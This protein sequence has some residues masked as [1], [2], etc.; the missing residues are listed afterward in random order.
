MTPERWR[1]IERLYH[2]ALERS[3][4]ERVG[5]LREA[6]GDD[7]ALR[8]E[9]ESLFDSAS[10]AKD[11]MERPA[12]PERLAS[13]M[14]RLEQSSVPGRFVGR[15]FGAYE[16]Q[17]LIAAGGMGEVYRAVDTRLNRTVAI[18]TLP[19]HLSN[20]PERRERFM[21]E[22]RIVSSLNHPHICTLHDVGSQDDID[23]LVM[24]HIDG[25]TLQ[26]RLESGR[27]PLARALEYAIQIVD[28]L[29]KAHRRGVIHRDLKPGNVMVTKSGVKLLDFGLA[30]RYTPAAVAFD[31]IAH[32]G[33]KGLTAKG[34]IVGTLQYIA[35]E[36]LE[37]R[38]VDTRTDIFAFG[39]LAYEMITGT[40]AF[41]AS[42]QAQL[43][44]AILK[45]NPQPI[46]DSVPD[47]P[48]RLAQ[49]IARCLAKDPD[50]RW[51]SANDLLFELRSIVYPPAAVGAGQSRRRGLPG[52]VER[53][54]WAAAIVA[55]VA[56]T[57][58]LARRR[59]VRPGDAATGPPIRYTLFPA[60]G[61][62]LYSR[63]GLPFALSP[64]GGQI[65]YASAGADG[66][67]QLWLRSLY[68]QREQPMPGTEGANTPFWST[69]SQWIGF[70]AANSL[71]KIRVSTGLTQVVA[72]NVQTKG[73]AAW[74]AN[75]VI[76]FTTG[77][78]GLARVSAQGG[79]VSPA[80]T[81]SEG[82]HF[83]PQFLGDGD[84]FIYAAAVSSSI[85]LGSLAS[86]APRMLMKF[87]VRIS[88]LAYVP[89][90]VFF[91]QD[92]TL[93]ARPFDERR[94]AFSGDAIRI[95][96][97][98]P[99]MAPG[100]AP[101]SVAA[102]G[103]LA[104]WPYPVGTPAALYWFERN[105][106]ASVAVDSPAQYIGFALSP[107]ASRLTFSR[108][109][110]SGGADVWV[111][112]LS[113]GSETRLT[114]DGAAFTP[115]W[116]PD[117][118]RI[119]FAGPGENPPV[120][121]FIKSVSS[122]GAATQIGVSK[123]PNFASSWSGDGRS[124]ASVRIDAANRNDLWVHRLQDNVDERLSFNTRFNES[125]GRVS[126]DSHW[127]AYDTDASG[128]SEVWVASFP[129]GEIRRQV[130]LGGGTSPQWGDG[131]QEIVYLSD[132]QRLMAA[133]I[134]A[135]PATVEVGQPQTLFSIK[136]LADVDQFAFPTSTSYVA[137]SNGQR[138]LVA[139]RARDPHAPPINIVVNW[140][141]LLK[142]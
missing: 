9:V 95:V 91:V 19:E 78:G 26:K 25:E 132:D 121:L 89:G 82:S 16:M 65:V 119:V 88:S 53:A 86:D 58:F 118:T 41:R 49:T 84:H 55:C 141:A 97:G 138:F 73:G 56:L 52:W 10:R 103:V 70:F 18:K 33:S 87:P 17:A 99:V 94:L 114:F 126:P 47:V 8:R 14:R 133:R 81:T 5:F 75:D 63:N 134:R 62:S 93:F 68:S 113:Q 136:N 111:R 24:E 129:S 1:A 32:D 48:P 135:M 4:D 127:I 102:A 98:I 2:A 109:G 54:V 77:P 61:T 76:L 137:A 43:V 22:A 67:A 71:K 37:G 21:R 13:A 139:V 110:T 45:D 72:T 38:P 140:P 39:A 28:A 128:N 23:Y 124:I 74:S 34:T 46:A 80:T 123:V 85:Y 117:G 60:E 11:F 104:Y 59:D 27:L 108:L 36:Q 115:Q 6:C 30:L 12:V 112:D 42:N 125:R 116:S 83:W 92:A 120:K 7:H 100:R 31:D 105:G 66:A 50:D 51:Q 40:T 90:Y 79:P 44:G 20:D 96:D 122:T 29:D 107:D 64:D 3:A 101:F 15:T 142:P 130:S 57:F 106:R 35:P 131:S 69:D